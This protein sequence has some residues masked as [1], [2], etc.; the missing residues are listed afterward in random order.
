MGWAKFWS[1]RARASRE[2]GDRAGRRGCGRVR[3]GGVGRAVREAALWH[4]SLTVLTASAVEDPCSG[5]SAWLETKAVLGRRWRGRR[6]TSR[7]RPSRVCRVMTKAVRP[8]P[9]PPCGRTRPS[10]R[11]R[12]ADRTRSGLLAG[13]PGADLMARA[14]RPVVIVCGTG[15]KHGRPGRRRRRP[16][17]D[18]RGRRGVGVRGGV[19]A[20][21]EAG[22]GARVARQRERQA[23]REQPG[24][25]LVEIGD[26]EQWL[27][28]QTP[29]RSARGTRTSTSNRLPSAIS[30]R[31][32]ARTARRGGARG[33]GQPGPRRVHGHGPRFPD[34]RPHAL[35][36]RAGCPVLVVGGV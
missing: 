7:R 35:L 10:A 30:P 36:H 28:A 2:R 29:G 11:A 17:P 4:T 12:P 22:R 9:K 33:R 27:L 15:A 24:S 18:E 14:G 23:V 13:S 16:Q 32:A 26:V 3:A 1:E 25:P 31:Q 21:H 5:A 19:A 8:A 6:V 34:P 20:E